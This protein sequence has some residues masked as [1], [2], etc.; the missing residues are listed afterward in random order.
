MTFRHFERENITEN[1]INQ[2]CA[3]L[4][5]NNFVK[6]G[7]IFAPMTGQQINSSSIGAP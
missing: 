6:A 2:K 1:F 4:L 3:L 7:R 5:I